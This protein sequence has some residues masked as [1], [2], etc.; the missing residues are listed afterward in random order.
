[1]ISFL[2]PE[3]RLALIHRVIAPDEEYPKEHVILGLID[4]QSSK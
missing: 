3:R 1:M 2:I 4:G